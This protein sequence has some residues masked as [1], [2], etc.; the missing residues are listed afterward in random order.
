MTAAVVLGLAGGCFAPR[1]INSDCFELEKVKFYNAGVLEFSGRYNDGSWGISSLRGK[2]DGS[3]I[4]LSGK[5]EFWGG[6]ELIAHRIAVPPRINEVKVGKLVIWKRDEKKAAVPTETAAVAV[7]EK[8]SAIDKEELPAVE[9]EKEIADKVD[10]NVDNTDNTDIPITH[11]KIGST[12]AA[13]MEVRFLAF[14]DIFWG[15]VIPQDIAEGTHIKHFETVDVKE[16]NKYKDAEVLEIKGIPYVRIDL[17]GLS[18][19]ELKRLVIDGGETVGLHSA[20][21]P[22]LEE[23]YLNDIRTV[24]LG[25][26]SLPEQLPN[27]HTVGIQ[28]FVGNFDFDSLRGKQIVRLNI[29]GDCFRFDFLRGMPLEDL[30]FSGFTAGQGD[31]DVLKTLPLKQLK[32]APHRP[33][34]DWSFL[35]GMKLRLLDISCSSTSNFSPTLLKD[36]PLEVLR[37][38]VSSPTDWDKAW[39]NCRQLPLEEVVLRNARI[40]EKFLTSIPLERAAFIHCAWHIADPLTLLNKMTS[41]KHLAIRRIILWQNGRAVQMLDEQLEWNKFTGKQLESLSIANSDINFLQQLPNVKKMAVRES[42]KKQIKMSRLRDRTFEIL[43]LP[44]QTDSK[45][46]SISIERSIEYPAAEW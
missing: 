35:N 5:T 43:S 7:P 11:L 37:I 38:A 4:I 31:L 3:S 14:E 16:L 2:I 34:S 41:V 39:E 1:E 22:A 28:A 9:P 42:E 17:T 19:P 8:T 25:K 21:L 24:P 29:H 44:P 10:K 13:V 6:E 45:H 36:M 46:P 18:L 15:S 33:I 26:I 20:E 27:L 30:K 32:L 40:P 12:R 23:F